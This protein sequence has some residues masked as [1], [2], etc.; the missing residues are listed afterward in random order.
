VLGL[1][2]E[3]ARPIV[4]TEAE[5]LVKVEDNERA[6][7]DVAPTVRGQRTDLDAAA[8]GTPSERRRLAQRILDGPGTVPSGL[9]RGEAHAEVQLFVAGYFRARGEA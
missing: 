8:V 5:R 6:F 1:I 4:S 9:P 7:A 3:V 2:V